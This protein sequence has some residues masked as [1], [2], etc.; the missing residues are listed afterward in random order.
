MALQKLT[1]TKVMMVS[2]CS[3]VKVAMVPALVSAS[4]DHLSSASLQL[5]AG[6]NVDLNNWM[7]LQ[8]DELKNTKLKWNIDVSDYN[9]R[10]GPGWDNKIT[11]YYWQWQGSDIGSQG[12]LS[13]KLQ[14]HLRLVSEVSRTDHI[15]SQTGCST[16]SSNDHL[17]LSLSLFPNSIHQFNVNHDIW[18][19]WFCTIYLK[20]PFAASPI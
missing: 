17:H 4:C 11:K 12:E 2:H 3:L 14:L 13:W 10:R 8:F 1:T 9:K 7:D 6:L 18:S 5:T 20:H 15:I 16:A 19:S